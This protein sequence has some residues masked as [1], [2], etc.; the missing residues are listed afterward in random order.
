MA[1]RRDLA[2]VRDL[3]HVPQALHRRRR[4]S[5]AANIVFTRDVLEREHVLAERRA[6][7]AVLPRLVGEALLQLRERREIEVRV[8]PLQYAH[9]IEG[10][11]LERLDDIGI[12]GRAA[13]GGA[14][15]AVAHVATGSAGDLSE[16]GRMELAEAE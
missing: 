4:A 8:A 13:P 6:D 1:G 12:E 7:K 10:V 16:L 5:E 9:R 11:V 15:G 3:A 2:V 14:E